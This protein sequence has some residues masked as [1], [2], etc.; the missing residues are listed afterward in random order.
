MHK[1]MEN[2]QTY[3]FVL[4]IR[5]AHLPVISMNIIIPKQYNAAC[6][7]QSEQLTGGPA[8]PGKPSRPDSPAVPGSPREPLSPYKVK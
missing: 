8:D 7:T 1:M 3:S 4:A 5:A 6:R 2:R